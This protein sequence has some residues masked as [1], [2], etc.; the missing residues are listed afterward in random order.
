MVQQLKGKIEKP[1][2][3]N[4]P[5]DDEVLIQGM[6]NEVSGREVKSRSLRIPG[7]IMLGHLR[8]G[9]LKVRKPFNVKMDLEGA[10]YV[11]EATELDEFGFGNNASE[12]IIDLQHAVAELYFTLQEEKEK[13]GPDLLR[14]W[15]VMEDKITS[16]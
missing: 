7:E 12:A 16:K 15:N 1:I 14:I 4:A 3:P 10:Q 8:D 5:Q 13:L 9:R 2:Y 11:A 6:L